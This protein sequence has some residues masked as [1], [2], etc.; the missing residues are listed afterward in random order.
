MSQQNIEAVARFIDAFNSRDVAAMVEMAATDCVIVAQRSKLEGAFTGRAGVR[1]W[2][3]RSWEWASDARFV[4]ARVVPVGDR[5]VVVLGRQTGTAD[6]GEAPFDVP[7]AVVA[8]LEA[9]LLKRADAQYTT[10]AEAL[11]AAGL[12]D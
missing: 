12:A 2:A 1:K 5:R 6:L 8:E 11:E 4:V 3:E 7:L 9:G 10:H